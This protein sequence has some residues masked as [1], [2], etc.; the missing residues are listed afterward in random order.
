MQG[1]S[2]IICAL[3]TTIS[4]CSN[5][6]NPTAKLPPLPIQRCQAFALDFFHCCQK[7]GLFLHNC[8]P[9]HTSLACR[10]WPPS[11]HI[12]SG[13]FF[14]LLSKCWRL[15]NTVIRKTKH[16]GYTR[17][18][19]KAIG[20]SLGMTQPAFEAFSWSLRSSGDKLYPVGRTSW[21]QCVWA[22]FGQIIDMCG[23]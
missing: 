12:W 3:G 2:F 15:H 4:D 9:P 17:S 13:F 18:C 16:A 19:W 14:P 22:M 7:G 5:N 20:G 10:K 23:T 21:C 11:M 8:P 1:E 6:N